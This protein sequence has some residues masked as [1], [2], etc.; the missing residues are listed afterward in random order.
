MGDTIVWVAQYER[1][2]ASSTVN[3]DDDILGVFT[4]P[5]SG[6]T[7]CEHHRQKNF[8]NDKPLDFGSRLNTGH[9]LSARVRSKYRY[10]VLKYE[11]KD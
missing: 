7:A 10:Y 4:T 9:S 3:L 8:P 5:E 2:A 1:D 6:V 11:L